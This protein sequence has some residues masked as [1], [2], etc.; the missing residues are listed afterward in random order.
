MWFAPGMTM[1]TRGRPF[2][3]VSVTQKPNPYYPCNS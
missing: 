1:Y 3:P 2:A